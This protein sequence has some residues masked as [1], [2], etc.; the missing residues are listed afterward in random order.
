MH[1]HD[2]SSTCPFYIMKE[3]VLDAY[4]DDLRGLSLGKGCIRYQ[5]PDQI[6]W[7]I[8]RTLLRETK[9]AAGHVCWLL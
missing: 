3:E 5:R 2:R 9:T 8:I 1:S 6:E 7:P 4:R